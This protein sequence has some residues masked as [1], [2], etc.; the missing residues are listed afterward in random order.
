MKKFSIVINHSGD[1]KYSFVFKSFK[2]D[3]EG[4][5]F[6]VETDIQTGKTLAE[7]KAA[8]ESFIQ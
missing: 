6:D 5:E 7:A 2:L 4:K 1:D 8:F 3:E